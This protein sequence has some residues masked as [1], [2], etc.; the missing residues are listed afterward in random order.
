MKILLTKLHLLI[1]IYLAVIPVIQTSWFFIWGDFFTR[2]KHVKLHSQSKSLVTEK[3]RTKFQ[4]NYKNKT[5][6][7]KMLVWKN[8]FFIDSS[9]KNYYDVILFI[10]NSDFWEKFDDPHF[11]KLNLVVKTVYQISRLFET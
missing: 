2:L 10:L 4:T 3:V 11:F 8:D 5:K 1:K 6:F 9:N 7:K